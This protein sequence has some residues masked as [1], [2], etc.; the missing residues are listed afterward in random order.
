VVEGVEVAG[1]VDQVRADAVGG[2][3]LLR[4]ADRLGPLQ[5]A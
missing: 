3:A 4:L 1:E 2:T 5:Q